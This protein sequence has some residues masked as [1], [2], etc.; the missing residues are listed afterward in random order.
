[1]KQT[2]T[3]QAGAGVA[4]A[5]GA[6]ERTAGWVGT[7]A[8]IAAGVGPTIGVALA[9]RAAI[10]GVEALAQGGRASTVEVLEGAGVGVQ[11]YQPAGRVIGQVTA[12]T[13]VA[14][15]CRM[16]AS[17][18]G[19]GL[20]EESLAVALETTEYGA[21]IA[22]APAVLEGVGVAG[23][24]FAQSATIAELETALTSGRSA[25]VGMNIPG[26]S[27]HALVV[28]RIAN[29]MVFIRDPLPIAQGSSF[30]MPLGEFLNFWSGRAVFFR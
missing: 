2:L 17:D 5:A 30:A 19:V 18:V 21:S 26:I 27:R 7:G 3:H 25:I 14:G 12:E 24:R 9:R 16:I 28:D 15:S 4:R 10:S 29:G 13:C 1:V 22:K 20:T 23:G 6:S 8:D 11:A